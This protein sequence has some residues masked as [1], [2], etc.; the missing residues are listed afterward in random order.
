[1][2]NIYV[3][4]LMRFILPISALT[5][6]S[7]TTG[8]A[9]APT[10]SKKMYNE[11]CNALLPG[12]YC[13]MNVITGQGVCHQI[14]F[15]GEGSGLHT[16]T[17]TN[18]GNE[19]A[20]VSCVDALERVSALSVQAEVEIDQALNEMSDE[21]LIAIVA[22]EDEA[23][24]AASTSGVV[25]VDE[26]SEDET[27]ISTVTEKDSETVSEMQLTEAEQAEAA[28]AKKAEAR[29][30]LVARAKTVVKVT[31]GLLV[32]YGIY[33]YVPEVRDFVNDYAEQAKDATTTGLKYATD[34]ASAGA[35]F[36]SSQ[37]KSGATAVSDAVM[38]MVDGASKYIFDGVKLVSKSTNE[39]IATMDAAGQLVLTK[40]GEII[41]SVN[42]AGHFVASE[43]YTRVASADVTMH[44]VGKQ[45][46]PTFNALMKPIIEYFRVN[47]PAQ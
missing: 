13:K 8:S 18:T 32:A 15:S 34:K 37:V 46:I 42:G 31:A 1:M 28:L 23:L 30:K 10:V 43:I 35:E 26:A 36:V 38:P 40:S 44:Q 7:G 16:H 47:Q 41:G 2:F 24:H 20:T 33:N 6:V 29:A 27:T 9:S 21:E 14:L 17:A 19:R 22:L 12:S 3:D 39:V 4:T 5:V 11:A 25:V 45:V